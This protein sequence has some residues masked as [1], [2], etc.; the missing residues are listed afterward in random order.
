MGSGELSG[1][2]RCKDY[3][4][5]KELPSVYSDHVGTPIYSTLGKQGPAQTLWH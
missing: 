2:S 1:V 3:F 4:G 5:A